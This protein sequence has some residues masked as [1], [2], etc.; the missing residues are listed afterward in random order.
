MTAKDGPLEGEVYELSLDLDEETSL[1][2]PDGTF[3]VYRVRPDLDYTDS[4]GHSV[5]CLR[6]VGLDPRE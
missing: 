2:L 3:A 5:R 6:F 1:R 4:T